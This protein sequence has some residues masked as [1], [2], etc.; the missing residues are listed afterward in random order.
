MI[1]LSLFFFFDTHKLVPN[2]RP[3]PALNKPEGFSKE[4][5]EMWWS[6]VRDCTQQSPSDRPPMETVLARLGSILKIIK[7][8]FLKFCTEMKINT[9]F[10]IDFKC[11]RHGKS[12]HQIFISYRVK[13]DKDIQ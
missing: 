8:I 9:F 12:S 11:K 10:W 6:L 5:R 4:A 7:G 1:L 2:R 3:I 13:S